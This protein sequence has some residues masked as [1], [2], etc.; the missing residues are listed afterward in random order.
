MGIRVKKKDIEDV[1]L[2]DNKMKR[3]KQRR[4]IIITLASIALL[5]VC[6]YFVNR[7]LTKSYNGYEILNSKAREDNNTVQYI[8]YDHKLIKYSRD[9]ISALSADGKVLWNAS[10]DVK[11]PKAVVCEGYVAV[12]DI[13]GKQAYTFNSKGTT[14]E[15]TTTLPI[16]DVGI[17]RQGVLCVTVEG[18]D[19]NQILLYDSATGSELVAK[20]TSIQDNGYP[21]DSAI[22]NDAKKLV[23]SYVRIKNGVLESD[24][25]F[26]NFNEVGDNYEDKLV[27]IIPDQQTV[28]HDVVFLDTNT[29]LL[30]SDKGFSLYEM[31]EKPSEIITKTFD[32]EIDSLFY[33]DKYFGFISKD[34]ANEGSKKL[35]LYNLK[36][37]KILTKD[38]TF[39]YESVQMSG[40][41]IIFNTE[42]EIQIIDTNGNLKF[43]YT[44]E[45]PIISIMPSND[46]DEYILIDD[47]NIV[48]IKLVEDKK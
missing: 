8:S 26:Y 42:A 48:H 18:E 46:K 38:I 25:G 21:V 36:G 30:C 24:V 13:G 9:G 3:H 31:L 14:Y 45:T 2:F 33:T 40:E 19:Y 32:G 44:L 43:K 22:S 5:A 17:S 7:F 35:L 37:K 4:A 20:Q 23:C 11:N 6:F 39:D 28:V 34:S 10:Y 47:Q 12:A 1:S 16:I 27:G 41:D 15:L 29:I